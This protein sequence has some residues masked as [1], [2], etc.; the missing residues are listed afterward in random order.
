MIEKSD[1]KAQLDDK[2]YS[3]LSLW[4][5]D[6]SNFTDDGYEFRSDF[7]VKPVYIYF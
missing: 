4:K 5:E 2:E 6:F 1:V 7:N 3:I